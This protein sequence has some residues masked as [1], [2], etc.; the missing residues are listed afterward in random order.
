MKTLLV[1]GASGFLGS[2]LCAIAS[3]AGWNVVGIVHTHPLTVPGV[4]TIH[5]DI[6]RYGELKRIFTESSPDAVIHTAAIAK[7]DACQLQ[8]ALSQRIN[9]A[10]AVDLAGLCS[11]YWIP[12][13][14]TSSDLVFDGR[15]PPYAEDAPL[16]PVNRYGAQK[17]SAEQGMSSRYPR[18]TVCRMPLMYGPAPAHASS[19]LQPILSALRERREIRLFTDEYRTPVSAASAA[20]GLLLALEHP[21]TVLHLGGCDRLSRF[22][23]GQRVA[24]QFQKDSTCLVPCLSSAVRVNAPR[25]PDVSLDSRK[26]RALGFRPL[27]LEEEL[28]RLKGCV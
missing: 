17:I 19:S 8:P 16:S 4:K 28:H 12:C 1:T 18:T 7:P 2:N 22:E 11:D 15:Q 21:G 10:A 20:R 24:R 27:P 26:A 23:F 6:T 9:V 14:F 13:V 25:A 5:A 3:T